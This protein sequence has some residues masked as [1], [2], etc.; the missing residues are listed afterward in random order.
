MIIMTGGYR[1][2]KLFSLMVAL[3]VAGLAVVGGTWATG[4]LYDG[5]GKEVPDDTSYDVD[6]T[7]Y[8]GKDYATIEDSVNCFGTGWW[9]PGKTQIV[10][11]KVENRENFAV[12][13]T[14]ALN[15][16][17]STFDPNVMEYAFYVADTSLHNESDS[18]SNWSEFKIEA[19]S[20]WGALVK[21]G[22]YKMIEQV[23][24]SD[25]Q[26]VKY[27]ALAIH[28]NENASNSNQNQSME[29]GFSIQID[30]LFDPNGT[31]DPGDSTGNENNSDN[32]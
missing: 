25:G 6:L 8:N 26:K 28:M 1:R 12:N 19:E 5:E 32:A 22:S 7:Y 20:N 10:Y 18:P 23:E 13:A 31:P 9:C 27:I 17:E 11:L 15:V 4:A 2:M 29:L 3:I 30:S 21:N 16:G 24:L 14:V